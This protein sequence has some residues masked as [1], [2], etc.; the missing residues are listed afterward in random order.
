[1]KRKRSIVNGLAAPFNDIA[2]L[3]VDFEFIFHL[4]VEDGSFINI[5]A[6]VVISVDA[7]I[8]FCGAF[9]LT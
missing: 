2:G 9:Y 6:V 1:M 8:G 7:Q 3:G 5:S 4:V